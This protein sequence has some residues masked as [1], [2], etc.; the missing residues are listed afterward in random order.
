MNDFSP[1][2]QASKTQAPK[3]QTSEA[4]TSGEPPSPLA[5]DPDLVRTRARA[6]AAVGEAEAGQSLLARAI[7]EGGWKRSG[8]WWESVALIQSPG[9]YDRIRQLWRETPTECHERTS[10]IRA[11]ARA[12]AVTGHHEDCRSLLRRLIL[13]QARNMRGRNLRD[14]LPALFRR[15]GARLRQLRERHQ[16]ASTRDSFATGAA[17]ALVD[18]NRA[19]EEAGARCFLIS[20][21]LLGLIREGGI[22]GWDKDIDVGIFTEECPED[23]EVFFQ[24]HKQFRLGRVDLSSD[25]VR[26]VHRNGTAI[27]IFPHYPE[28][29]LRWHDGTATRWWNTPFGLKKMKFLGIDQYVPEDP[30]KYL[31]ENYGDW[32]TPDPHFDARIDA[33][34]AEII[35]RA[36]Y[37]SLLYFSLEKAVRTNNRVMRRRYIEMLRDMGEGD[38]LKRI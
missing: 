4:Q 33:P 27:D 28:G 25:R 20:G 7:R 15:S 17:E 30:E 26:A 9:D 19:F 21:T 13:L 35:D 5:A 24:R 16:G 31:D 14:R 34:N 10:L 1:H 32:R 37:D 36:H 12:A 23:L 22:I 2:T 6:L 8:L 29:E 38:W 3:K 11:V 18:L